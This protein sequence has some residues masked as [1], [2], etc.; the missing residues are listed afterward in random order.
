MRNT[1]PSAAE[2]AMLPV[3]TPTTATT[4][5]VTSAM[6]GI[7]RSRAFLRKSTVDDSSR[8]RVRA[9]ASAL[10]VGIE[11]AEDPT[12]NAGA[13]VPHLLPDALRLEAPNSKVPDAEGCSIDGVGTGVEGA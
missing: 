7:A 4:T 3:A 10:E 13:D 9:Y 6:T 11:L 2:P 8:P 1:A 5:I 12:P